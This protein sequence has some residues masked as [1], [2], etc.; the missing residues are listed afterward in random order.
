MA[1]MGLKVYVV[2]LTLY[3]ETWG[4]ISGTGYAVRPRSSFSRP[5]WYGST[6]HVYCSYAR[7][8]LVRCFFELAFAHSV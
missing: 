6:M 8:Q 1:G 5:V 4:I 3:R 2:L 7:E